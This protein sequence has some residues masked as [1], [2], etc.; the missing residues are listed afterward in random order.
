MADLRSLASITDTARPSIEASRL[1]SEMTDRLHR[2][3][4]SIMESAAQAI[5]G[6]G[7]HLHID[8]SP[9]YAVGEKPAQDAVHLIV[10]MT[11]RVCR[12]D[13]EEGVTDVTEEAAHPGY[14]ADYRAGR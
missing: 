10:K 13:H 1:I 6:T 4:Y 5:E 2:E 8:R 14:G 7:L 11:F 3:V 9:E 12:D